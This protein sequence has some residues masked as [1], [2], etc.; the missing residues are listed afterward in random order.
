MHQVGIALLHE[1]ALV[2]CAECFL[3][4]EHTVQGIA[5]N[6]YN[7]L[8]YS[9]GLLIHSRPTCAAEE[10]SVTLNERHPIL[11]PYTNQITDF[12]IFSDL[13][14]GRQE[15]VSE[16]AL[17]HFGIPTTFVTYLLNTSHSGYH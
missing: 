7:S 4:D 16:G 6:P 14:L 12:A 17:K 1:S 13:V 8:G 11:Q 5:D 9:G 3:K 10:L 15:M 2:L